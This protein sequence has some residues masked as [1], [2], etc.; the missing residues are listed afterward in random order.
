MTWLNSN[1]QALNVAKTNFVTFAPRNKPVNNITLLINKIAINQTKYVKY[2]GV[3][4]DSNLSFSHHISSVSKKIS[5]AVGIMFKIDEIVP[6]HTLIN[7]YYSIIYP[8][9]IYGLPIWGVACKKYLDPIH[10]LQKKIV[11]L[12]TS[13]VT[14][15]SLPRPLPRSAPL[16]HTC[17]LLNIYDMF[18]LISA[19]F[20]FTCLKLTP[21][22]QFADFYIYAPNNYNTFASQNKSLRTPLPRTSTY[23]LNTL[24]NKGAHIWNDIPLQI[25]DVN[26]IKIF[27][28]LLQQHF[29]SSY[30]SQ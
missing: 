9:L 6:S 23:G 2:L 12:I 4:I 20:V 25:R 7:L 1:R 30:V 18:K 28:K 13:N 21:P 24:R 22:L 15:H 11:C 8:F 3:L 16:F 19:K 14:Y 17:G 10:K 5:R 27:T 26:D 29:L